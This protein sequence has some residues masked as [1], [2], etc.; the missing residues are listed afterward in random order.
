VGYLRQHPAARRIYSN[1]G[2]GSYVLWSLGPERKVFVDGRFDL[3]DYSGVMLDYFQIDT[4]GSR[5]GLLI[6]K[7][8]IDTFL[9]YPE[10]RLAEYLASQA[11]WKRV[12]ADEISTIFLRKHS[13]CSP[14]GRSE[15]E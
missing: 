3:Y 15:M 8:G 11:G 9:I 7:Y 1:E 10:S 6:Q 12:Y 2:W 13:D 4:P 5:T 14:Q